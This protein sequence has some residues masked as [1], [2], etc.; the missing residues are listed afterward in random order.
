MATADPKKA[1]GTL[2]LLSSD[3]SPR[4]KQDVLRCLAAPIGSSVQ[5]RYDKIEVSAGA[6]S[7]LTGGNAVFPQDGVVCSVASQG[8]GVLPI[9][10]VRKVSILNCREHGA[11]ISLTL[12]IVEVAIADPTNFTTDLFQ[13]TDQQTPQRVREGENPIGSYCFE[14]KSLPAGFQVGTS[15][16]VWERAV[17]NLRNQHAYKD[18]PFFWVTLG[19]EGEAE[20]LDADALH[21]W[22]AS[23]RAKRDYRLLLYHFQPRDGKRPDSTMQ[24]TF[25]ESLRSV[26]PPDTKIDSRYDLKSWIFSATDN[27]QRE[28]KTWLRIR[29]ADAWDLDLRLTIGPSYGGWLLRSLLAG[30][31]V[32]A[33]A[34]I[35]LLPQNIDHATKYALIL[36]A[37]LFGVLATLASTFKIEKPK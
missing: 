7:S 26:E 31:L 1:R 27:P 9:V 24:V 16:D 13:L 4:Y 32:A 25:G 23:L 5:F 8:I 18:E 33:P 2:F 14:A 21:P 6:L 37:I 10:P 34:I 11:T 19:V 22:P 12:R 35:A 15:L 20:E 36:W 3:A 30:P 28:Q 17:M 29:A